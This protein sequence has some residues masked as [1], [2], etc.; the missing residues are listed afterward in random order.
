[1]SVQ[2]HAGLIAY[3]LQVPVQVTLSRQE[4]IY[5]STKRHAM[6]IEMTTSCDE[7]GILTGMKAIILSDTGAY[8]SLGGPVLQRACTH[9][10]GPYN[11]H[12]IQVDGKAYYTNNSPG[13]A[14]RGFG[15]TQS[16][17]ATESNINK[18]AELVGISPWEIRY[19]NAIR[20]GQVLP[21]GQIADAGTGLVETLEAVKEEFDKNKHVGIA[22]AFKNAGI[23]V[24]LPDVGKCRLTVIDG[25]VHI[26][27]SAACI[28]QGVGTVI[29]QILCETTNIDPKDVV[30]E[31]PDTHITPNSG[32]TTASR[33]TVF[34]GE[35]TRI[36]AI[37][38]K[39]ALEG[40]TLTDINGYD[41]IGEYSGVTDKIGIDKKNPKS[42]IAYGYATQLVVLDDNGKIEKV[43]AAHDVGKAIN[44]KSVEGQIEGG[45]VMGLGFAL[46][47]IM[48]FENGMP[49]VKFGTLGLLR[50][51]HIPEIK[52]III[53]KNT[54]ELAYGAK[55]V[56]EITVIPT[57]PA[58]QGAYYKFDGEFRTELPLKGTAY[59]K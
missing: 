5:V 11:Y 38:L 12:N 26:R 42:H 27:T 44:P 45:V 1:M 14:F 9:A 32:T 48:P 50:A 2:H 28:G 16:V 3:V 41:H 43:V 25:K 30:V 34:T 31:A 17:F 18:L 6:E 10:S 53:E 37:E 52:S 58:V 39:K 57:A 7:N 15:V 49:K 47:E 35:A 23:G 21:N 20:P 51:T 56:G 13:G 40:K 24:G 55:G 8:S 46:T 22:C 19:K 29:L 4:S 36:A 54:E 59:K 33:Q